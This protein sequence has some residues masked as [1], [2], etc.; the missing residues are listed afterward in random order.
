MSTGGEGGAARQGYILIFLAALA[1]SLYPS[2]ARLSYQHGANPTFLIVATTLARTCALVWAA[3][4]AGAPLREISTGLSGAF[5]AGLLQALTIVAIMCS[6]DY[7]P[8]PVMCTILFTHTLMLL[9]ILYLRGEATVSWLAVGS[10]V[11]ALVG[12]AL[13]VDVLHNLSG[14]SGVGVL[15]AALAAVCSANRLYMYGKQVERGAAEVVGARA[16]IV[17]SACMPLVALWE[18]PQ[19]PHTVRGVVGVL[20]ASFS[21]ASG[22]VLFFIALKKIGSFRS[23]LMLKSE[24][25]FNVITAWLILGERLSFTQYLGIA[26]VMGSLIVYQ[27]GEARLAQRRTARVG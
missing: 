26:L 12:I 14:S 10:S 7:L 20:L 27:Y 5:G 16:F 15:W 13:V 17:A 22:T 19:I 6:L 24:P 18:T 23:S 1:Y 8:G 9:G 21:L 4:V 2:G 25:I 11:V 3:R